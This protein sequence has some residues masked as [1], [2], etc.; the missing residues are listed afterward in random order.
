MWKLH[1][2][3]KSYFVHKWILSLN[4]VLS[5]PIGIKV[6]IFKFFSPHFE[7]FKLLT[8]LYPLRFLE[9][10]H[11]IVTKKSFKKL[12]WSWLCRV[13]RESHEH[14]YLLYWESHVES[15]DAVTIHISVVFSLVLPVLLWYF[16]MRDS[17]TE[18]A[19]TDHLPASWCRAKAGKL[20]LGGQILLTSCFCK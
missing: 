2:G 4:K 14:S 15:E 18:R 20:P 9:L 16:M 13:P 12:N 7:A 10:E 19:E 1:F 6:V 5:R 17:T 3:I 8:I 11:R